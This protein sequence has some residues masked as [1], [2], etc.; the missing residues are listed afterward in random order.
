MDRTSQKCEYEN[1]NT[2]TLTYPTNI[3]RSIFRC[4]IY[5]ACMGTSIKV[6]PVSDGVEL[7]GSDNDIMIVALKIL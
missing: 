2:Q 3:K 6:T 4:K 7:T 5:E 1:M